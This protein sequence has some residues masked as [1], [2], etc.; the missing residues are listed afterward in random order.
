MR[1]II[2]VFTLLFL[3]SCSE[4]V[5]KPKKLLSKEQMSAII[6]DFAIYDQAYSVRPDVNME[7]ASR[8]VLQKNKTNA[9]IYRESYKYYLANSGELEDIFE[10]AKKIILN[11]DSK[12][13]EYIEKQKK[14]NPNI[15]SFVK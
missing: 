8:Y 10:G 14:N 5:D 15:P 3:F 2:A 9:E 4:I 1:K 11:K 13:E 6:A 12:L 7:L